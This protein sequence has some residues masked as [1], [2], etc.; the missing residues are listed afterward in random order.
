MN[1]NIKGTILAVCI[2]TIAAFCIF[3]GW[4]A[5]YQQGQVDAAKGHWEYRLETNNVTQVN[6]VTIQH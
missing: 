4:E 6:I 1:E 5:G 3:T 2:I